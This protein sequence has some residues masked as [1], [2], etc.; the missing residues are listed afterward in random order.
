[1]I[2]RRASKLE[3]VKTLITW[4]RGQFILK[5]QL[6]RLKQK[7]TERMKQRWSSVGIQAQVTGQ[8]QCLIE[9]ITGKRMKRVHLVWNADLHPFCI[10]QCTTMYKFE[11]YY[12]DILKKPTNSCP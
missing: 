3:S 10:D 7:R 8:Y 5:V 1:M 9:I 4:L 2:L 12:A 11:F 6:E